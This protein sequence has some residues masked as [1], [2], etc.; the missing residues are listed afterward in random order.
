M[1]FGPLKFDGTSRYVQTNSGKIFL[2]GG[3]GA[4]RNTK[5]QEIVK[6]GFNEYYTI[7]L[8]SLKYKREEHAICFLNKFLLVTGSLVAD[9]AQAYK[10]VERYDISRNRWEELAPLNQGRAL[11][12]SC[13]FDERYAFVFCGEFMPKGGLSAS[14]EQFDMHN[15]VKGWRELTIPDARNDLQRPRQMPGVT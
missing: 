9:L 10:R 11:H 2:I 12:S 3:F 14:I 6:N 8:A 1:Y 4:K 7:T 5:C 13:A 15:K